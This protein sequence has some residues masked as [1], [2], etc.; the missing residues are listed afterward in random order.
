M[1]HSDLMHQAADAVTPMLRDV[2]SR[3]AHAS[4]RTLGYVRNEPVRAAIAAAAVGTLAFALWHL[5]S[6]RNSR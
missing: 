4:D 6:S 3:V 5:L 1:G 2:S